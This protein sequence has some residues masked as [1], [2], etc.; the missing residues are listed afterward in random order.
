MTEIEFQSLAITGYRQQTVPNQFL[1]QIN[2]TDALAVI[3]PGFHYSCDKPLL[4]YITDL[5][6]EHGMDVLQLRTDYATA[7]FR[8][9]SD[10][11]RLAWL[12][13]DALAGL[14]TGLAQREYTRLILV[15][16]SIG[17]LSLAYLTT[18]DIP[19]YTELIWL[20]PLFHRPEM[21]NAAAK[22]RHKSLH[23]IGDADP[24]YDTEALSKI[25]QSSFAQV[26][27]VEGVNHSLDNPNDVTAS[28]WKM[29]DIMHGVADFL[30][31]NS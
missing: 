19:K 6:T 23:I 16:K 11:D 31:L 21:V 12:S 25:S 26:Q 30:N 8:N 1:R 29:A 10:M 7:D 24:N 3:Y 9:L 17:T 22:S 14:N 27:I 4:Y 2:H 15:G 13:G 5:L 28:I 18:Q 20:T